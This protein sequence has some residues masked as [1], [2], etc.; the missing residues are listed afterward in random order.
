MVQ[1]NN[2]VNSPAGKPPI[3]TRTNILFTGRSGKMF[4]VAEIIAVAVS[5][6]ILILVV[7]SYLYFL[8]PARSTLASLEAE[9]SRLQQNIRKSQD[10]V[11]QGHD[12]ESTVKKISDSLVRFETDALE[13]QDEGRMALYDELNQLIVKDGLRNTS[14]PTYAALD[15]LGTR[16]A[17]G[18]STNT[19]W[20]TAYPGIAVAVT[21][22]G[23]YQN[24]R[25][26]IHD[27]ENS[28]QFIVI[29]EVELE[30]ATQTGTV[31]SES[32]SGSRGSLVSLQ[33]NMATYFQRTA[34]AKNSDNAER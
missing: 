23:P 9:R 6:F 26:F 20:Q 30:R 8:L 32:S 24:V 5:S 2:T 7:A 10:I 22:E 19:K 29:N 1:S 31:S 17:A 14:G 13:T 4:G 33:L 18:R 28:R 25:K 3:Q 27:I 15:P 21:V 16:T 12:T 11:H 34:G